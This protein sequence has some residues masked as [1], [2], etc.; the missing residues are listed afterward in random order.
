[1]MY[2]TIPKMLA[3]RKICDELVRLRCEGDLGWG[4]YW[5]SN[6]PPIGNPGHT[7][8]DDRTPDINWNGQVVALESIVF[9]SFQN[10]W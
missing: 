3:N 5:S 9:H 4:S 1:M 10:R 8:K 7:E 6:T 2:P